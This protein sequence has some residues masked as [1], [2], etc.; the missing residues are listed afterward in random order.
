MREFTVNINE[1][2]KIQ[3]FDDEVLTPDILN[4]QENEFVNLELQFLNELNLKF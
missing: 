3:S 4:K 1:E 2:Q